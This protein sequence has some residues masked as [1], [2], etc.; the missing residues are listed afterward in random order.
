[1]SNHQNHRDSKWVDEIGGTKRVAEL[2]GVTQ[3]YVSQW[4]EEGIPN[5]Y[6]RFLQLARP[7]AFRD[8]PAPPEA[9]PGSC[10]NDC[11]SE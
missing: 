1:M 10:S 2:C 9:R 11:F 3:G 4:R 8:D 6:R 5:S 7:E